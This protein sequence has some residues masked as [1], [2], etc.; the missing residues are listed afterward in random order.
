MFTSLQKE[1]KYLGLWKFAGAVMYIMK[2]VFGMKGSK[3]I[4]PPNGKYGKFVLNEVLEAGNFGTYDKRNRFGRSILGHNIQKNYRDLRLM[5]YFPCWGSEWTDIQSVA[6]FL[7]EE[8]LKGF[9]I[10]SI[11]SNPSVFLSIRLAALG[12]FK[13]SFHCTHWHNLSKGC[14]T[15]HPSLPFSEGKDVIAL[16]CS[17]PLLYKVG[18]ASKPSPD[19]A[20]WDRK[21]AT[22]DN[23]IYYFFAL[24]VFLRNL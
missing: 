15:S 2:E 3:L 18:G 20:S 16:W 17:E 19:C 1:L 22:E 13:A 8:A 14:L 5:S 7:E 10:I 4:V 6:L 9:S 23:F 21:D 11:F 24:E 12:N